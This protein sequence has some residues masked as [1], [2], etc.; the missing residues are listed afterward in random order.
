IEEHI[1]E[2]AVALAEPEDTDLQVI[3]P[4]MDTQTFLA[5]QISRGALIGRADRKVIGRAVQIGA[6]VVIQERTRQHRIIA[7]LAP[8]GSNGEGVGFALHIICYLT[9]TIRNVVVVTSG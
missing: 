3:G 9:G 2:L 4:N 7:E 6:V 5:A 8:P 1:E